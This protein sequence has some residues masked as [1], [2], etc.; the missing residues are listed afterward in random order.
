MSET[1][2]LFGGTFDPVH[3]GHLDLV[4]LARR[5]VGLDRVVFIPCARSPFKSDTPVA[6]GEQRCEMLRLALAENDWADWAEVSRFEI[7]RDPPSWS[8]RSAAHFRDAFPGAELC[9]ILGAD[10]W[11]RIECWAEPEKLRAWLR[12]LVVTRRGG[13]AHPRPGWRA[14]FLEFEH[15]ASSTAIREGHG[16]PSWLPNSVRRYG[17]EHGLYGIK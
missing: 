5:T 15:P 6:A 14:D 9:W 8:W 1:I 4:A 10:Q 11:Q 17:E 13:K 12:F 7:D 16:E 3:R 2:A